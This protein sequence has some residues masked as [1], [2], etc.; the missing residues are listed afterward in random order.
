MFRVNPSNE[1]G[2]VLVGTGP[3]PSDADY[4]HPGRRHIGCLAL[5]RNTGGEVLL[6]NP[7][8]EEG[9][10]LVGGGARPDEEAQHAAYRAAVEETGLTQLTIG[11]LLLVDYSPANPKTGS[12]EG[13]HLVFDAGV[14]TD[15]A[16]I[17]LPAG[18]PGQQPEF[19]SWVFCSPDQLDTYCEP[20]QARRITQ[21]LAA[22]AHPSR[23]GLRTEGMPVNAS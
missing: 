7:S 19:T 10:V 11:D 15:D 21:A 3:R 2:H 6:V 20:S 8:Y 4:S 9:H 17:T 23:R 13:Y 12:V 22:L 16:A 14:V 5:I 1:E 18:L